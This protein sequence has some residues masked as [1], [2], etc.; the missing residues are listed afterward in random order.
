MRAENIELAEL[1]FMAH[2]YRKRKFFLEATNLLTQ[3]LSAAKADD[4]LTFDA[5][6]QYSLAKVYEEQGNNFFAKELYQQALRD[7]LGGKAP[8]PLHQIWPYRSLRSLEQA[9]HQLIHRV[10]QRSDIPNLPPPTVR[11]A[12]KWLKAG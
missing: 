7:W 2:V 9:C 8:N 5:I 11:Q 4:D 1:I 3:A 12:E 6:V 10:E